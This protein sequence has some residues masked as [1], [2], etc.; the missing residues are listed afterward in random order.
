MLDR[1]RFNFFNVVC[2]NGDN[3]IIVCLIENGVSV[4][5]FSKNELSF[6]FCVCFIGNDWLVEILIEVGVDVNVF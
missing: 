2:L 3:E 1:N 5:I 6:F 4:N